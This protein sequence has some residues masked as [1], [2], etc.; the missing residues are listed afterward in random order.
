MGRHG[1]A[2]KLTGEELTW[3]VLAD[4]L[5]IPVERLQKETTNEQFEKWQVY[6]RM[7]PNMF[8]REDYYAMLLIRT[9]QN[10]FNESDPSEGL[11]QS[12]LKFETVANE[13]EPSQS[14]TYRRRPVQTSGDDIEQPSSPPP[15][16]PQPKTNQ[17]PKPKR[18]YY[19]GHIPVGPDT[20]GL[21]LGMLGLDAEG[22][23]LQ[24]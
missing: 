1:R 23:P 24:K 4:R 2:K 3:Y 20:K 15:K 10:L 17:R 21:L 19:A 16:P 18:D 14:P 13:E 9:V 5:G 11:S 12:L 6:L 8:H 22:K 7:E